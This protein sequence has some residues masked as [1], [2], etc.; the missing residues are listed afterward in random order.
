MKHSAKF[1]VILIKNIYDDIKKRSVK[2][3]NEKTITKRVIVIVIIMIKT[4]WFFFK[5]TA[6]N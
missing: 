5:P 1:V 3:A 4:T 2:N 6:C